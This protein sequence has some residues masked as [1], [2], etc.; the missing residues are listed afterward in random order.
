LHSFHVRALTLAHGFE[1]P[2]FPRGNRVAQTFAGE[3][4]Q[5]GKNRPDVSDGKRPEKLRERAT[6]TVFSPFLS[7]NLHSRW[8]VTAKTERPVSWALS[9]GG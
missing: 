2:A 7:T 4:N 8:R 1:A 6:D 3:C 5:T 9:F